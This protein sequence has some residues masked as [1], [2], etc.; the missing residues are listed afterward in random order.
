MKKIVCN[1]LASKTQNKK[2][3]GDLGFLRR[4]VITLSPLCDIALP[5]HSAI[6]A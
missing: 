6:A 2:R 3:K 5:A 4:L 1:L